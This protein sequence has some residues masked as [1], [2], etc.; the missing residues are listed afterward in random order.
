MQI[1]ISKLYPLWVT[2]EEICG[3]PTSSVM[4]TW[5]P[6]FKL[7]L[8]FS[9]QESQFSEQK[10]KYFWSSESITAKF[11]CEQF[12]HA[13]RFISFDMFIMFGG[14]GGGEVVLLS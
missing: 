7:P 10:C 11:P 4:P 13:L 1:C 6:V 9:L 12:P 3:H 5:K 2:V 8:A 14:G